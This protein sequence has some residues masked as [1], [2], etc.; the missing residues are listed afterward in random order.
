MLEAQAIQTAN[1][2]EADA[3]RRD[4]DARAEQLQRRGSDLESTLERLRAFEVAVPSWALGTG[5]TRFGR[6]PIE[7][8]PRD[9]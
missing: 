1:E 8:E 2:T 6:F 5:G 7:G 4:L 9:E 3:H